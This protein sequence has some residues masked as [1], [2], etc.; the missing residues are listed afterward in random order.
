MRKKKLD[1]LNNTYQFSLFITIFIFKRLHDVKVIRFLQ[2]ALFFFFHVECLGLCAPRL[3]PTQWRRQ[4]EAG[5]ARAPARKIFSASPFV[6]Y[7]KF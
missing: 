4:G 2:F 7:L 1:I 6:K 3:I 5:R